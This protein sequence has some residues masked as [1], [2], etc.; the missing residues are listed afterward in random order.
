MALPELNPQTYPAEA[1]VADTKSPLHEGVSAYD[2]EN[3]VENHN[4]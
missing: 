2:A 1:K 4:E 3:L